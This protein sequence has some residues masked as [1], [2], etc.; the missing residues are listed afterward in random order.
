MSRS[1]TRT[2][3]GAGAGAEAATGT[4]AKR[5]QEQEQ[6]QEQEE[7]QEQE[8][9]QEQQRPVTSIRFRFLWLSSTMTVRTPDTLRNTFSKLFHNKKKKFLE[10]L[11]IKKIYQ[12]LAIQ[13]GL[14]FLANYSQFYRTPPHHRDA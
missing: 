4:G 3:A 11:T 6:E 12:N 2:G 14:R 7:E 10:F 13:I 1:D 9:E 5:E 8:Q